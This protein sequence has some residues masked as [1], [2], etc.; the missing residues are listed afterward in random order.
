MG[1]APPAV[2][3]HSVSIVVTTA[4]SSVPT[5]VDKMNLMLNSLDSFYGG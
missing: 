5:M 4:S 3:A 1:D 2:T